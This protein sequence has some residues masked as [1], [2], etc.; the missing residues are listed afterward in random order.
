MKSNGVTV[1]PEASISSVKKKDGQIQMKINDSNVIVADHVVV[2]VGIEPNT[3][4]AK[5]AG[6]ELDSV[7][8]GIIAN[9][10][11]E[12]NKRN[13][14]VAGDVAAFKDDKLGRLRIEHHDNAVVTGK[15]AGE[16]MTGRYSFTNYFK[17]C[18]AIPNHRIIKSPQRTRI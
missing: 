12:T 7:N 17:V 6:L 5:S 18:Y 14:F 10:M 13:I 4:L 3:E 16:N 1:M 15:L 2:A 9:N 11:L 8:G